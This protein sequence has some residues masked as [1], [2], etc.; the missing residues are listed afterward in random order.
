MGQTLSEP[1]TA[2]ES[3]AVQNS[4]FKVGSSSMQGWRV[5]MEDAH[6]H[7]LKTANDPDAS[8]FAVYD[9]H[10]G[11]KIAA[12]VSKILHKH[13]LGRPEYKDGRYEEAIRAGFL[14]CDDAMR[15]DDALRD[16]MSGATAITC[17]I[18]NAKD[19]FVNNVGDSRCV[20]SVDGRAEVLSTDHK[21]SDPLERARIEDA[22]GFVEF[23]RVN[24][25]LALSRA[26]GD[27][28]FKKNKEKKPE[29]Q[30]VSG[31][32]DVVVRQIDEAWDFILLACDG[33][34]DVLSNQEVVDFVI[35]RLGGGAEPEDICEELMTRC[36]AADCS[37]GGLGCDNMTV[38]LIATLHDKPYQRL[39]DKAA[40]IV[41]KRDEERRKEI[42]DV[43]ADIEDDDWDHGAMVTG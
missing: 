38:I 37:M 17:L 30:I 33:I 4:K 3:A 23:N 20:A 29:D 40:G 14:E 6:T 26:L 34:W 19:V 24:G 41:K 39:I 13:I 12:E 15:N 32:P 43:D 36:L 9:G 27:F 42:E 35:R 11:A 1:I 28:A 18:R 7:I 21:P 22:G 31:C 25:N 16:E 8:F 2:K 5:S 10:G